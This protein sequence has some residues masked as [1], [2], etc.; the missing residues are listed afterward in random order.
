MD[1]MAKYSILQ[2]MEPR[3]RMTVVIELV[4]ARQL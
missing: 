1:P 4:A 2:M 3:I